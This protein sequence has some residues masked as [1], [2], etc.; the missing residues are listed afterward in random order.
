MRHLLQIAALSIGVCLSAG[1]LARGDDWPQWLGPG[2]DSVWRESG[3]RSELPAELPAKWRIAAGWGYAG[4]AVAQGKVFLADYLPKEDEIVNDAG[5]RTEVEG[6]ERIRCLDAKTGKV[7]WTYQ[8][9]RPYRI[10]YPGGPRCTPTVDGD[11][12][13]ALGAEGDLVCLDASNGELVWNKQF[14]VDY[15]AKSPHWGV[16]AHPLVDDK[17]V[18]CLVGGQGS[19]VVA[20]D[21][22]TGQERWRTLDAEDVGYS[23]ASM[24]EREGGRQLLVWLPDGLYGLHPATG[25][26]EWFQ[27][28]R[29]NYSM[30][31]I[32]PR[33]SGDLLFASGMGHVGATY[34]LGSQRDQVEPLWHGKAGRGVYCSNST[35]IIADGIIY[36]CDA[37]SGALIA[38]RL[39]DGEQ[40]WQTFKPTTGDRNGG[41]GTAF[42]VQHEDRYFLFSET[43]DLIVAK[44][45]PD[46][47]DETSRV[48]LVEPTNEAFGRPVVWTHPAFAD[49]CVFVRN[50]K[51]IACFD[52]SSP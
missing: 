11:R 49:R 8:Y 18:Y 10:S 20:F 47:Y 33:R 48:R 34:R 36:G 16:S 1:N 41:H 14:S 35:P 46:G 51:E 29:P 13:Y 4:P 50:D 42:L 15:N 39:E 2:G 22:R 44:L 17:R 38:C 52:L 5:A 25:A 45:S 6:V 30:S 28:L 40:L 43:G 27:P 3:I 31:I 21:K 24:L 23:P 37:H 26:K 12:V 7:A 32:A 9:D 19:A